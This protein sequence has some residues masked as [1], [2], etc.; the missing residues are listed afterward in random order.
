MPVTSREYEHY[1]QANRFENA[2]R[3]RPYYPYG[4]LAAMGG[5][6]FSATRY[7][8]RRVVRRPTPRDSVAVNLSLV[9]LPPPALNRSHVGPYD[10]ASRVMQDMIARRNALPPLPCAVLQPRVRIVGFKP[11]RS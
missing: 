4:K 8:H 9:K 1:Y 5:S 11:E 7:Q 10:G 3:E 2:A 6:I